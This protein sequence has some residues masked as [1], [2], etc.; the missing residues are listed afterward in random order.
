M[1]NKNFEA[2]LLNLLDKIN[3]FTAKELI[4]QVIADSFI[5]AMFKNIFHNNEEYN[6]CL[7]ISKEYKLYGYG[8]E[9]KSEKE[10]KNRIKMILE[11]DRYKNFN[12]DPEEVL[13]KIKIIRNY[14]NL[15]VDITTTR[16]PNELL[17]A[18]TKSKSFL[19]NVLKTSVDE[20]FFGI[21]SE[22]NHEVRK[23]SGDQYTENAEVI[24]LGEFKK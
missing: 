22:L 8:L 23:I 10:Q 20:I 13:K 6:L 12:L 14:Y 7:H 11:M 1:I 18:I 9:D 2:Q 4:R 19:K 15:E 3:F 24:N 16:N 5:K 17:E 21:I